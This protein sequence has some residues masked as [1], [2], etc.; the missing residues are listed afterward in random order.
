M[1]MSTEYVAV[2]HT[3][4]FGLIM[5]KNKRPALQLTADAGNICI[6]I[7]FVGQD[8]VVTNDEFNV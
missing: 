3:C 4:T 8:I 6:G 7:P 5:L 1:N 2:C